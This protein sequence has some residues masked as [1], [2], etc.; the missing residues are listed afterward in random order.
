[1]DTV[2]GLIYGED[3]VLDGETVY[4]LVAPYLEDGYWKPAKLYKHDLQT[5]TTTKIDMGEKIVLARSLTYSKQKGLFINV[6][7][8]YEYKWY[9]EHDNGL[10]AN[11]NG[12]IYHYDGQSITMFF[13]N[14]DGIFNSTFSPDGI[15]YATDT[16]GKVFKITETE[17]KL[18]VSGLFNMLKNVNFCEDKDIM[19]VTCFGGGTYR[20]NLAKLQ[21]GDN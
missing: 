16:Y 9:V 2:E 4:C 21:K 7:P 19:Y 15:M 17:S 20:I 14:Q 5:S 11:I 1:M 10:F 13:E 18:L 6:I 3:I 8:M 12:G